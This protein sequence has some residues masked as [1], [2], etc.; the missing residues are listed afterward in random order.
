MTPAQ[1]AQRLRQVQAAI[2]R[3][4]GH[5]GGDELRALE[6]LAGLDLVLEPIAAA[7]EAA[8]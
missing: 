5:I 6:E 2:A 7:L 8:K 4:M 1:A 3:A